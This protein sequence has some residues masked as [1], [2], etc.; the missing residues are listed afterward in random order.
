VTTPQKPRDIG[1]AAGLAIS[2]GLI[3][4]LYREFVAAVLV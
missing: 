2:S 1:F 3:C 4:C